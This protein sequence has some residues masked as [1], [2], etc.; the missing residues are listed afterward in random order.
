MTQNKSIV[1]HV[2]E[3]FEA[4]GYTQLGQTLNVATAECAAARIASRV[5][6][7]TRTEVIEQCCERCQARLE[8]SYNWV[9]YVH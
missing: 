8:R 7:D 5:A 2:R 9:F 6:D 1:E 4:L 3:H